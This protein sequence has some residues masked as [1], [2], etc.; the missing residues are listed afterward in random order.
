MLY[1]YDRKH[2][3]GLALT[4]TDSLDTA[5]FKAPPP[6]VTVPDFDL[7]LCSTGRGLRIGARNSFR[8]RLTKVQQ[9][10]LFVDEAPPI[11][12]VGTAPLVGDVPAIAARMLQGN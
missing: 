3:I 4:N 1:E 8:L 10:A 5:L 9:R 12:A 6:T 11:G 7:S 2:R